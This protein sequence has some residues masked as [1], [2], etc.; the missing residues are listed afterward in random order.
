MN[1]KARTPWFFLTPNLVIFGVFTFLPIAINL[2][3][4]FTGGVQLY[5]KDRPFVGMENLATLLDCG[6][7]LD[8]SSCRKDL[9]WRAV[10]NTAQFSLFQVSLMVLFGEEQEKGEKAT[11]RKRGP[12]PQWQQHIEA[13]ARLPRS[14]QQFVAE[15]LRNVL[16]EGAAR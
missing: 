2:Y 3:Y 6:S 5:P 12:V 7:Y 9:F 1:Q 15:M 8:P 14:R 10:W 11:T 13:I 16:G 4:A